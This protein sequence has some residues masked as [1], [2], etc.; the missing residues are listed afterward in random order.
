M[1]GL[2]CLKTGPGAGDGR[3]VEEKGRV[4][5]GWVLG[6]GVIDFIG[7]FFSRF[8]GMLLRACSMK[9]LERLKTG[10]LK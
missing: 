9:G 8:A 2:E 6:L 1:R 5:G 4:K 10:L 3:M 7:I